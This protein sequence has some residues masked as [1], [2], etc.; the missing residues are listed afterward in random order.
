M[1]AVC[2]FTLDMFEEDIV[3][4]IARYWAVNHRCL[5][6]EDCYDEI[7]VD[8]G[9]KVQITIGR[10]NAGYRVLASWEADGSGRG[11]ALFIDGPVFSSFAEARAEGKKELRLEL[12]KLPVKEKRRMFEL[13]G[14][15]AQPVSSSIV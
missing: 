4:P 1:A 14:R 13:I 5:S 11:G 9:R 12:C 15:M 8:K 2:P 7:A 10:V 6:P 3:L